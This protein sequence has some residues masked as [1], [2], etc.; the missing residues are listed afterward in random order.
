MA[1]LGINSRDNK[2]INLFAEAGPWSG[3]GALKCNV[4]SRRDQENAVKG[5]FF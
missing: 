5:L 1:E 4:V 2:S 3:G